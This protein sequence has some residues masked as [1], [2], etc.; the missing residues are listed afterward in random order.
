VAN[1]FKNENNINLTNGRNQSA[2]SLVNHGE[3]VAD[4]AQSF[5][6]TMKF[7]DPSLSGKVTPDP[8]KLDPRAVAR[9]GINSAAHPEAVRENFYDM[10]RDDALEYAQNVFKYSYFSPCCGYEIK[11]QSVCNKLVDL[12]FNEGKIQAVKIIQRA[13]NYVMSGPFTVDGAV[14]TRTLNGINQCDPVELL[15]AIKEKARDFYVT[16]ACV[17]PEDRKDLNDWLVRADA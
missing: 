17:N 5:N 9:F 4:L 6:Y 13:L 7:E 14:G 12:A 3:S 1:S 11:D 8:S 10:N 15:A 2:K 16:L